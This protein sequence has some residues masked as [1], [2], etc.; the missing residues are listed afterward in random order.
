MVPPESCRSVL[1]S[2]DVPRKPPEG[3]ILNR[4]YIYGAERQ[5]SNRVQRR[6]DRLT[7]GPSSRGL[8]QIILHRWRKKA[9]QGH[10]PLSSASSPAQ[11]HCLQPEEHQSINTSN[12]RFDF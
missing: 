9:S 2:P 8:V 7:T 12:F 10:K 6:T 1:R 11:T 3:G 4:V 5:R